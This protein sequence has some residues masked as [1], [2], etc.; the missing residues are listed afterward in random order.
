MVT[1]GPV[2]LCR[3]T[4]IPLTIDTIP[5][6][7]SAIVSRFDIDNGSFDLD[8]PS[9]IK[10]LNVNPTRVKDI[11]EHQVTL[12]ITN[13]EG[14][15]NSC[16]TTV[17][18]V[19]Q[20]PPA[21]T[22]AFEAFNNNTY[23]VSITARDN[24]DQKPRIFASLVLINRCSR[25]Q[26]WISVKNGQKIII[27]RSRRLKFQSRREI[28]VIKAPSVLLEAFAVDNIGNISNKCQHE[29]DITNK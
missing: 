29:I 3:S 10:T 19:D 18:V 4:I 23:E 14:E 17:I 15:S 24:C 27:K 26:K 25:K 6:N 13:Q 7:C 1:K 21:V 16:E 9:A 20:I 11:G 22:C 28:L 2:A 5:G 8:G 12:T